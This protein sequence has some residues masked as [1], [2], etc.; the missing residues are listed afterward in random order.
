M[1]MTRYRALTLTIYSLA[2]AHVSAQVSN[3][4]SLKGT[5]YFRQMLML[6]DSSAHF[7]ETHSAAGTLIFD[8]NGNFTV[9]GQQLVGTTPPAA[10]SGSGTY[11]VN[12]GGFTTLSNPA[13]A[14]Y[15]VNARLGAGALIGSSTEAGA[16]IFDLLVAIPS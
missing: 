13:L 15:T 12:P 4:Q 11:T 10:L 6:T 8:G 16:T 1:V 2:C 5:Y 14:G 7:V 3:N 9:T